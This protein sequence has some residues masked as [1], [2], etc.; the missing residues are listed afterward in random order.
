MWSIN[1]PSS[2]KRK[3]AVTLVLIVSYSFLILPVPARRAL[4]NSPNH[5][6]RAAR[7]SMVQAQQ[8]FIRQI[9]LV[10]N[11]V[12]FSASTGK[13]YASVPSR[14]GIDGHGNTITIIN[15]STGVIENSIFIGSEPNLLAMASD[16]NSLHVSLD[17]AFAL[18]KFDTQ[19]QT[20]G[21]Q[22]LV[23]QDQFFGRFRVNDL[24]VAP[25]NP[26]LVAVARHFPGL[27]P[28]EAGVAVFDTGVQRPQTG[29]GHL[30]GSD[31]LAFSASATKLYGGGFSGTL[32]TM[33]IDSSGVTVAGTLPFGVGA[34]IKFNNGRI[35]SSIGQVIDPDAGTLLGT[36]SN[37]T[38]NAFVADS[39]VGRAYY[40]V[41]GG[42]GG[43]GTLTLRA[44]DTNT[45]LLVG[46]LAIPGA[47]GDPIT[48]V[49]WGANGLALRTSTNQLFLIQTSLIPSAEPIPTP[50]PTPSPTASPTPTPFATFVRQIPLATNDLIFDPPT[51]K[52]YASVPS[53][54]GAIGNSI[55][56]IDPVAGTV[57]TSTFIGSEP[58]KIARSDDGQTLQVVLDGAGSVRRFNTATQTAGQQFF[59]GMDQFFG[60][61]AVNDLAIAPGN[62]GLVAVARHFRGISPPEAGVVV[63]D[64]GVQRPNAGPGHLAGSDFLAFSNSAT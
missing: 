54:A 1:P 22:F 53:T 27:S 45:F 34:R 37:A 61:Y 21:L 24:A 38:T 13:L 12:V 2:A 50:T 26:D 14:A 55:T 20:P 18:R 25:G 31:F 49:R 16:G 11:D 51:Q 44:F 30:A 39:T 43:G 59:V 48:L 62:S 4:A 7:A 29:P 5:G 64:N 32:T 58:T 33:N 10:T 23:G 35:F 19:T 46:T 9:P 47:T 8:D 52:L 15:P 3:L 36:F 42:F 17:G 28:P 41:G 6:V 56:A 40:V 57:G 63:F 60:V